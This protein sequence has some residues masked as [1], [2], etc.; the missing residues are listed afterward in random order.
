ME[1]LACGYFLYQFTYLAGLFLT[2]DKVSGQFDRVFEKR[3]LLGK[4]HLHTI[5]AGVVQPLN[6][7]RNLPS[8][9]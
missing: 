5:F 2:L 4:V 7:K 8:L 9:D 6:A 1:R 3:F